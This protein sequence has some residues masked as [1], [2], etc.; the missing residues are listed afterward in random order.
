MLAEDFD[1]LVP[2]IGDTGDLNFVF[3]PE[4]KKVMCVTDDRALVVATCRCEM[5]AILI[6]NLM[7]VVLELWRESANKS[8]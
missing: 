6:K 4:E 2:F 8:E 3:D 1:M 7:S 5:T